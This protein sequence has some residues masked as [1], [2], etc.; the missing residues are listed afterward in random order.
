MYQAFWW[1]GILISFRRMST[2][3]YSY[4]CLV[5]TCD[6]SS[7]QLGLPEPWFVITHTIWTTQ[8]DTVFISD[9]DR[10]GGRCSISRADVSRDS[11]IVSEKPE[12]QTEVAAL[13]YSMRWQAAL[14]PSTTSGTTTSSS[15]STT[16][17]L[18]LKK[19]CPFH[20]S[21]KEPPRDN[22]KTERA[23]QNLQID[24]QRLI[25]TC[26]L[27]IPNNMSKAEKEAVLKLRDKD[28]ILM[29][30]SDKGGEMVVMKS[31]HMDR[32][33]MEHLNDTNTYMRLAKDTSDSLRIK[34]NKTLKEILK[35]RTS[36]LNWFR[37][38]KHQLLPDVK[39]FMRYPK[40]TRKIWKSGRLF[41]P[42]VEFSTAW[43]GCSKQFSNHSWTKF[44]H[45]WRTPVT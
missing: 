19:G 32:L 44:R 5:W 9:R 38:S 6:S 41:L 13:A 33:C 1:N 42:V 21:R 26:Q 22:I 35:E 30:R 24:L 8:E 43:A 14:E 37:T 7:K 27:K 2:R 18:T 15:T 29:T 3:C 10:N 34:I 36:Q 4:N 11:L 31:S 39:N 16:T 28:D 17:M 25:E 23:I 45:I 12:R 40:H 20:N